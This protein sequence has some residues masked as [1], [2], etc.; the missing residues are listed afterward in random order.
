[1]KLVTR[2][3]TARVG[4][5]DLLV[6]FAFQGSKPMLPKGASVPESTLRA[7]KGEFRSLRR[8]DA[9]SAP[10]PHLMVIGLGA[11]DDLSTER[12]R[13]VAA[14][15]VKAA[16]K[17]G[18]ASATIWATPPVQK[19]AGGKSETGEALAEGALMG[20]YLFQEGKSKKKPVKLKAVT[21]CGS[22]REFRAG[23]ARGKSLAAAN[24]FARDLGNK[25]A[26]LMRPRDMVAEARKLAGRS[27]R[28]TCKV[29]NEAAM[30]K[31]GMGAL[32]SVSAGSVE[33]AFLIH[34]VYKPKGRSKGRVALVGKGLTFDAGGISIKPSAK[35]W[36]MK[37]DMCGAAAVL[38]AFHAL[39]AVDV[40]F[41]V[42]GLVATSEN[43]PD[44]AAT[45]PGDLV[46]AMNGTTIEV[47]NTDAEGRLVLSDALC[48]AVKKV[49]ADTVVDLATLTGAVVMALGHEYSGLFASTEELRDALIG[50]GEEV[51]EALW[52]LPLADFHKKQMRGEVADLR[53]INSPDQGAGSTAG[54]A[55]LA[56][57]VGDTEWAHIDIAGAAWGGRNRDWVGGAQGSGVGAR[58]LVRWLENRGG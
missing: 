4:K 38:G 32:L 57:F 17:E 23:V 14:L 53:N 19:A 20:S 9:A 36:D 8:T 28:L 12:L 39:A 52:P 1:M 56:H 47:L 10:A 22:G 26:N 7:F 16:E 55:F 49:K 48:Y 40:P 41:E 50:A 2:D 13:R 31:L 54:A 30:Q 6:V 21:L 44:A 42:H 43:L 58:L 24:C 25:P 5:T 33:P 46:T 3:L 45:K 18:F 37:Y 29:L 27:S 35:M 11:A 34:L 51:G 15:A